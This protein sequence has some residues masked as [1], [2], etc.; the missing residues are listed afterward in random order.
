MKQ[1]DTVRTCA[2]C[3]GPI[4]A[5]R[6]RKAKYCHPNCSRKAGYHRKSPEERREINARSNRRRY[7]KDL[8]PFIRAVSKVPEVIEPGSSLA[9]FAVVCF[10]ISRTRSWKLD[11]ALNYSQCHDALAELTGGHEE[12]EKLEDAIFEKATEL[13][14]SSVLELTERQTN[15]SH[16]T[17]IQ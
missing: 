7:E 10:L 11:H 2:H 12:L 3:K 1:P 8:L 9:Q 4:P 6:N 17:F 15:P 13:M 16:A 14:E 5:E